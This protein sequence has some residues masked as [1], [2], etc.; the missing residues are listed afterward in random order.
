MYAY[1]VLRLSRRLHIVLIVQ[2]D[3]FAIK[4]LKGYDTFHLSKYQFGY[5]ARGH[6]YTNIIVNSSV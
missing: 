1:T 2:W 3:L 6:V 4:L 5:T